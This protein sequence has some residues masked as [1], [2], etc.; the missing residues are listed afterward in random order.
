MFDFKLPTEHLGKERKNL[1]IIM[2]PLVQSLHF[3][4]DICTV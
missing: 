1:V 4:D 3:I 2:T